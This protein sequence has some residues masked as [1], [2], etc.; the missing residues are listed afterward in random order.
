MIFED[1]FLVR[2]VPSIGNFVVYGTS[3]AVTLA[4]VGLAHWVHRGR[5]SA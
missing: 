2:R 3:G 4:V 1:P 5:P